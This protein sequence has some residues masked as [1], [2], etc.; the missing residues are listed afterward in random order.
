MIDINEVATKIGVSVGTVRNLRRNDQTFPEPV[1][2]TK[3]LIRWRE[4]EIESWLAA[5]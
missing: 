3:R 5:R 2:L 1:R 4:Q